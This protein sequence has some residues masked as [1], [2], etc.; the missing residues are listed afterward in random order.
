MLLAAVLVGCASG[1]DEQSVD[2]GTIDPPQIGT[3]YWECLCICD[4]LDRLYA[5]PELVCSEGN[6]SNDWRNVMY[7]PSCECDCTR[8]GELEEAGE[9]CDEPWEPAP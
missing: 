5:E 4:A 8:D 9:P 7:S 6:P 1:D 2:S 3:V